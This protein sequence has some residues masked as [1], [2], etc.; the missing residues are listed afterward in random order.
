VGYEAL[1]GL[2]STWLPGV[3]P[4]PRSAFVDTVRETPGG[5]LALM[6]AANHLWPEESLDL[7]PLSPR[8]AAR[9]TEPVP[10]PDGT[11]VLGTPYVVESDDP[12]LP[13]AVMFHDSYNWALGPFLA[14]HF[15]RI[16]CAWADQFSPALVR[17]EQPDV[18][19]QEMGERK[20]GWVKPD[21]FDDTQ[22]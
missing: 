8:R 14:E 2:L 18:V 6:V 17:R 20:L 12:S 11:P 1:A 22:D 7:E 10:M 5:D 4:L 3:R 19:I 21:D 13:R 9:T 15:R 16:V